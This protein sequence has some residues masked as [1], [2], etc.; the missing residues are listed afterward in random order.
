MFNEFGNMHWKKCKTFKIAH[1]IME[2]KC[3][4]FIRQTY[5]C[6]TSL[7][8]IGENHIW[9]IVYYERFVNVLIWCK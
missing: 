1:V 4:E 9:A 7:H 5:E 6:L 8:S 3:T 2:K